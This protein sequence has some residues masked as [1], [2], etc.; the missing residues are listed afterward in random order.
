LAASNSSRG[1]RTKLNYAL[2]NLGWAALL[3]GNHEQARTSYSESL[4][5]SNELGDKMNAS[6]SLDGLACISGARGEALRAGRLFGAAQAL[7]VREAAAF[8]HTPQEDAWR[9]PYR[10]NTRS[11]LGETAWEEALEQGRAIGLEQAIEYAL[12]E[13][14][15]SA[16][17]PLFHLRAPGRTHLQ[18]G[19][20]AR[21]CGLWNDQRKD[22]QGAL[23][24]P[25]APSRR[26]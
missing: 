14:E 6:E 10:A 26:T 2:D 17:P 22:R 11:L 5:V 21:A 16:T 7:R 18:G 13:E 19:R 20:G 23:P 15:P 24:Q 25:P 9:E 8:Q 3:Q 1:Y 4:M 12:S